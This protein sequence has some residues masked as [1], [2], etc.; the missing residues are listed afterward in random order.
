[1]NG[2]E[3]ILVVEDDE[4]MRQSC[5]QALE[6]VGH[7]VVEAG[8]VRE[9]EPLLLRHVFDLVIT[10]LRMPHGGGQEMLRIVKQVSPEVPVVLIT[11][12]PS[13]ESAIEAFRGG[14]TD[15]LLKPFTSEQLIETVDNA[16]ATRRATE[17][18]T[19]QR[20]IGE[21]LEVPEIVGGSPAIRS[22]L[23]EIRKVA[24]LDGSVIVLG[25]TGSGKEL[26]SRAVHRFSRR[27]N[28]PFTV[29]NCAAIPENLFEAELF[30]YERGA[31]TGALAT[32]RGLME[33]AHHGSLFLD[34]V[35]ELPLAAQAKLLRCLEEKAVRRLGSVTARPVD[36]RII[37]AT[38]KDLRAEV[39]AGRFREDLYY[40]LAV[41]EVRVPPLRER[42]EDVAPL[43]IRI[44][45]QLRQGNERPI[46]GFSDEALARLSEQPWPGNVRELQNVL[47]RA[48]ARAEGTVIGVRDLPLA[49]PGSA[50]GPVAAG[51]RDRALS[52]FEKSY[53][54]EVLAR[55]EGNV[56]HTA[57]ALGVHRTTLQRMMKK[58]AILGD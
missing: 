35:A 32:K 21:N 23:A 50:A 37:A 8:S 43:A 22:M 31:F 4:G 7:E 3:R 54:S 55:H 16:V 27:S 28:G 19:L 14:V 38:H 11:A 30:G 57:K 44:L 24:A 9:A 26:V 53:V 12:Y 49:S 5:R 33:E 45:D 15:Y 34:E 25:E 47:Q 46:V 18:A 56:T 41:L 48:I 6:Q 17:R 42:P 10:D 1:M 13:V 2:V 58:L 36:T 40:R 20:H 29:L 52:E 39:Q 51:G